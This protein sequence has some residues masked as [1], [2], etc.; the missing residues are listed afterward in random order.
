M[1]FLP[2]EHSHNG[3]SIGMW[4][5]EEPEDFFTER[6]NIYENEQK[7]LESIS[8]PFKRLEWLSSRLSL[9]TLLQIDYKVESLNEKTG[10]PYLSDNSFNISYSHSNLYAGAIASNQACVSMDLEDRTKKRN[11][12]TAPLFMNDKELDRFQSCGDLDIFFLTWS[13]KETLYKMYGSK[14]LGFKE[15][16]SIEIPRSELKPKGS[17]SGIINKD[18]FEKTYEIYYCYFP[19]I[20][21]TYTFDPVRLQSGSQNP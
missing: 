6:L 3:I 11:P 13:G 20:L 12:R 2:Y 5:V 9:K 15:N 7:I 16:L 14:G 21:L 18:G 4:K 8:H 19:N 17:V 1:P 10:K